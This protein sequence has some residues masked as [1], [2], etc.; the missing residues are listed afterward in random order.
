MIPVACDAIPVACKGGNL[1]TVCY[2]Y[3]YTLNAL[4]P[5]FFKFAEYDNNF[6]KYNLK[7]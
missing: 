4:N 3:Y 6:I 7:C 1:N 5:I 2:L